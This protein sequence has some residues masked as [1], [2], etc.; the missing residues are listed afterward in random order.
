MF[1]VLKYLA[2][3]NMCRLVFLL[4]FWSLTTNISAQGKLKIN[5]EHLI[6]DKQAKY[7]TLIYKTS[8]ENLFEINQIQYFISDIFLHEIGRASCR[9]RV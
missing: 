4:F 6:N 9:E 5:F 7:D 1:F 8:S 3:H 2:C